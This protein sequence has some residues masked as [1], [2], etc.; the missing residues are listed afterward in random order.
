MSITYS[1]NGNANGPVCHM[2]DEFDNYKRYPI[3]CSQIGIATMEATLPGQAWID[4]ALRVYFEYSLEKEAQANAD[5]LEVDLQDYYV[6][7][8]DYDPSLG[9]FSTNQEQYVIDNQPNNDEEIQ[10]LLDL[11]RSVEDLNI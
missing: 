6:M 11:V 10:A 7:Y 4:L 3:D 1:W 2:I 5:A 9:S 8:P